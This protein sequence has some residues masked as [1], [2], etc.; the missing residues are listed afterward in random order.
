MVPSEF[1]SSGSEQLASEHRSSGEL[2]GA[3]GITVR[4][5]SVDRQIRPRFG[6][7]DRAT[8]QTRLSQRQFLI[9]LQADSARDFRG[10]S[11]RIRGSAM[12]NQWSGK[13]VDWD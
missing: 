2:A 4:A 9:Q 3:S 6:D 8:C 10:E 1:L 5:A 7:L 12:N 11:E 13:V